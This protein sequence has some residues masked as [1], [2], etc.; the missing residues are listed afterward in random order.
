MIL[1]ALWIAIL[2]AAMARR[3][4][5]AIVYIAATIAHDKIF[6]V[7]Q[8][9]H[10]Y[11]SSGIL[12]VIIASILIPLHPRSRV[13]R[14]LQIMCIVGIC[15][16]YIGLVSHILEISDSFYGNAYYLVYATAIAIVMRGE[17]LVVRAGE[18]DRPVFDTVP[19]GRQGLQKRAV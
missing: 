7:G 2:I 17:P 15:L 9:I 8:G 4:L 14:H 18:S 13:A 1:N 10:Y 5:A 19:D 16:D 11:G 3:S 12:H 6:N